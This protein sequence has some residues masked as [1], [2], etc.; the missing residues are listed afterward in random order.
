LFEVSQVARNEPSI[1]GLHNT[2]N[3]Q[4]TAADLLEPFDL[5]Q[6]IKCRCC[7]S[8]NEKRWNVGEVRLTLSAK[9]LGPSKLR[10]I[11]SLQQE[12]KSA[13]QDLNSTDDGR[14]HRVCSRFSASHDARMTRKE[15]RKDIGVQDYHRPFSVDDRPRRR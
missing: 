12:L 4:I 13:A 5:S 1:V 10:G 3:Q 9:L 2:G 7:R 6:A 8:V 15:K 14:G 11:G